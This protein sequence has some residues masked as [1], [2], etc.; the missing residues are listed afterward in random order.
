MNSYYTSVYYTKISF[1]KVNMKTL[2]IRLML[3]SLLLPAI[4][5]G[6]DIP[7]KPMDVTILQFDKPVK[8]ITK[9]SLVN[10]NAQNRSTESSGFLMI[11]PSE[12]FMTGTA[13]IIFEDMSVLAVT[14]YPDPTAKPVQT[15]ATPTAT[16]TAQNQPQPQTGAASPQQ[17]QA[18]GKLSPFTIPDPPQSAKDITDFLN[19][20]ESAEKTRIRYSR[21]VHPGLVAY[22]TRVSELT[23]SNRLA[24]EVELENLSNVRVNLDAKMFSSS[25]TDAVSIIGMDQYGKLSLMPRNKVFVYIIDARINN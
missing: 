14:F 17:P 24:Y 20:L 11:T 7:V 5:Y 2:G 16:V 23:D 25:I 19:Q 8:E 13:K 6:V 18:T 15:I 9:T 10:L 12:A 21:Q 4:A 22:I 1:R 3:L